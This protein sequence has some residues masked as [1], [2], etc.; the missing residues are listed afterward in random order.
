[1]KKLILLA[2]P[3]RADCEGAMK[4]LVRTLLSTPRPIVRDARGGEPVETM[5]TARAVAVARL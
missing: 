5:V 4:A 2:L 1:M 3:L